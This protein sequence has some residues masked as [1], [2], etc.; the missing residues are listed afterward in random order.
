ME[1]MFAFDVPKKL[2][3]QVGRYDRGDLLDKLVGLALSPGYASNEGRIETLIHLALAE[4][5]GGKRATRNELAALLNGFEDHPVAS[6]EDPA[7]DVFVTAVS[8][9]SGQF[10]LFNGI[11]P[12]ADY[13]L[14]RLMDAIFAQSFSY[15]DPLQRQCEALLRVS[16]AIAERC[17]FAVNTVE[18]STPRR[19]DWPLKLPELLSRGAA[20]RFTSKELEEAGIDPIDLEPF[21]APSLDG[22][23]ATTFGSTLLHRYPIIPDGDGIRLA[24][25]SFV[26]PALR[27]YLAHAIAL[28]I[29][30]YEAIE[31]FHHSQFLRWMAVDLPLRKAKPLEMAPLNLPEPDFPGMGS[32]QAVL[33]FDEDKI[34]HILVLECSWRDPPEF[35]IHAG[36]IATPKFE[37]A[38]SD[39][40]CLV[41]RKLSDKLGVARGLT[42]V[43]QDTPGW[44][45]N[46]RLPADFNDF[47][48][49]TGLPARSLAFLFDDPAFSLI[50]LWKM[51]REVREFEASGVHLVVWLDM[52]NYW[53]IW[54]AL[55]STFWLPAIDLREFGAFGPDTSKIIETMRMIRRVTNRHASPLI[56]GEWLSVER[57]VEDLSPSQDHTKPIYLNAISMP[58]GELRAVI[59]TDFGPWW[60]ATARPPFDPEDRQ[61]MFLVWQAACEWLLR[62]GRSA[63]G[64][65]PPGATP[66]EVR[67]LLTP[68]TIT[69]APEEI[70]F[71][72]AE[73][74][75]GLTIIFPPSLPD[76]LMTVDNAGEKTLVAA[77][78]D[79]IFKLRRHAMQDAQRVAWIGELTA[80]P[81][82]KMIH[83]TPGSDHG[84]GADLIAEKTALRFLQETDLAAARRFV[85]DE[86]AGLRLAEVEANRE[87]VVGKA[88]VHD[89]LNAAV[90]VHWYRCRSML[91]GLDRNATI[92]L[93]SRVIE[94]LLRERTAT[95]RSGVARHIHYAESPEYEEMAQLNMGRRDQ[96][97]Q[98]YRIVAEMAF[99]ESPT[100]GGRKPGLTDID[101][102][103]A[104]VATLI[105]VAHNSDAVDRDL[106]TPT[107]YFRPD[108][109][110]A[111][112]QGGAAALIHDYILANFGES[113]ALD[114]DNYPGLFERELK[115]D[116]GTLIKADDPFIIAFKA[117]FG[118]GLRE[119]F[120]VS[121]ALQA[122]AVEQKSDVVCLQRS[123][124][125][126][127]LR[128]QK[129]EI[130]E[131]TLGQ[132]FAAFGLASRDSWDGAPPKPYNRTDVYPWLFERRLSLM[133]KPV[134]VTPQREADQVMIY[135]VRQLGMGVQYTSQLLETGNW[136]PERL[137]SREARAWIDLEGNRRG[138]AFENEVAELLRAAHWQALQGTAMKRLGAP[139]ET[140][141][142]DVLGVTPDGKIWWLIEC[143]WFGAARTPRE[144]ANWLLGF[145]GNS[146]DK[147][148][149]HLKR[150]AWIRANAE[151]VATSLRLGRL[152]EIVEPKIITTSPVPLQILKNLPEG[153]DV[154]TRRQ[155]ATMLTIDTPC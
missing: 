47:W 24:V 38:L 105:E 77:L 134:L 63:Q 80:D 3:R 6:S 28:K 64:R 113:L 20:S 89:V 142:L 100:E 62:I 49:V 149:R 138:L 83:V 146:G 121:D 110:L 129:I 139:K 154:L 35:D 9:Q 94:A 30:P 120:E 107:L 40:L 27:L 73:G 148:D 135:G 145:R 126:N 115:D 42:L 66:L 116:W 19:D 150:V 70:Q 85:R 96:S 82:L 5:R 14:Q 59:E 97:Y 1:F 90:D 8:T 75:A 79:A 92:L 74:M 102:I 44:S 137:V 39:Y 21:R 141:D 111:M 109:A 54:R 101:R 128:N 13:S 61:L 152:P 22:L 25:P 144:I 117:E 81:N 55:G 93:V 2:V 140:G 11:Y 98:A 29:V 31:A 69:D 58:L 132:F 151:R 18:D 37:K 15:H 114:V 124:L 131:A 71:V 41:Q 67:L 48:Y 72:Q 136:P 10:R 106:I 125:Q 78:L 127:L 155:L 118:I 36:T 99:C 133:L 17:G 123:N 57:W 34:V 4:A 108:G 65:L 143:K 50:D 95:E 87:K 60:V 91:K 53:S 112:A 52:L 76:R 86:L 147:L 103:A 16:D 12:G 130:S 45:V 122:L 68:D 46:A 56:N 23:L 51:L 119:A 104:E 7:E 26:S 153:A 84:Y 43:I 88:D 33:R 32:T